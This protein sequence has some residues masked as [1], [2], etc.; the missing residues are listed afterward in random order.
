MM[1]AAG[2]LVVGILVE[3]LIAAAVLRRF[4]WLEIT[5][6]Q[7]FTWP[8]AVLLVSSVG[9]F[10]LVEAGVAVVET[11]LWMMI[12]PI[13]FRTALLLSFVANAVTAFLGWTFL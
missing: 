9:R 5:A 3:G 12:A 6:I 4:C 13:R 10:W 7:L 1:I 11:G 8:A 2:A